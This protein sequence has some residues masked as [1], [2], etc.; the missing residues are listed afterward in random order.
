MFKRFLSGTAVAALAL[1][2]TVTVS[3]AATRVLADFS[4]KWTMSI[5][6]PDQARMAVLDLTQTGDSLSGTMESE[7]GVAPTRGVVRGDSLYFGFSIDMGGQM[8]YLAGAAKVVDNEKMD[9][10]LELEGMGAF[11]FSAVRQH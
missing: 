9:G 4:G 1:A 7:L 10:L 2:L 8:M 5:A 3:A 6:S 11:P